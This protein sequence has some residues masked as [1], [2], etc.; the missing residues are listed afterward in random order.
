[1]AFSFNFISD[2]F[3]FTLYFGY[4]FRSNLNSFDIWLPVC[5]FNLK[6]QGQAHIICLYHYDSYWF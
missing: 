3:I 2:T 1:M 6:H 5:S 4:T